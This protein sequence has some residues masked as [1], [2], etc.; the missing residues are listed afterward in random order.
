MKLTVKRASKLIGIVTSLMLSPG[1][2]VVATTIPAAVLLAAIAASNNEED[3]SSNDNSTANVPVQATQ[4][5]RD[6]AMVAFLADTASDDGAPSSIIE[7]E[8]SSQSSSVME[9]LQRGIDPISQQPPSVQGVLGAIPSSNDPFLPAGNLPSGLDDLNSPDKKDS[10]QQPSGDDNQP[11]SD[12]DSLVDL[13]APAQPAPSVEEPGGNVIPDAVSL[14]VDPDEPVLAV[15]AAEE[16]PVTPDDVLEPGQ[17][18]APL[19]DPGVMSDPDQ[20]D[21]PAITPFALTP[22]ALVPEPASLFLLGAGLLGLG[23][24]R[25]GK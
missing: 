18:L 6:G 20:S 16:M 5:F 25:R 1:G 9:E 23:W 13:G 3:S 19:S 8:D 4:S 11:A 14:P 7:T 10:Q 22:L 24:L 21:I 17:L 15:P 12:P 2:K